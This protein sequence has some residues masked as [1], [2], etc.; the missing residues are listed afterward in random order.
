MGFDGDVAEK[1]VRTIYL[2]KSIAHVKKQGAANPI[3]YTLDKPNP[4][5]KHDP[6]LLRY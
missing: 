2:N 4:Y 3:R 1:S 6:L 5:L